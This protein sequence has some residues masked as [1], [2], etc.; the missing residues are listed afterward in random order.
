MVGGTEYRSS[1]VNICEP[2]ASKLVQDGSGRSLRAAS[3]GQTQVLCPHSCFA[4]RSLMKQEMGEIGSH[5]PWDGVDGGLSGQGRK[6]EAVMLG[7]SVAGWLNGLTPKRSTGKSW[8]SCVSEEHRVCLRSPLKLI[9]SPCWLIILV[10][11]GGASIWN[12]V[13]SRHEHQLVE[14]PR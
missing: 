6:Q 13:E 1:L 9:G 4:G 2:S 7:R 8:C 12:P 11:I 3:I 14:S 10:Q 5:G